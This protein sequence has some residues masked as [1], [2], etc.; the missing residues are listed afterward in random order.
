MISKWKMNTSNDGKFSE[1]KIFFEKHQSELIRSTFD[2]KEIL[3]DHVTVVVHKASQH[4]D[5]VLI[6]DTSLEVEGADVGIQVK[7]MLEDLPKF[8]GRKAIW[9]VY[10]AY[11]ENEQVFIF[12]GEIQGTIVDPRGEKGFGF[13]K[14]FQPLG[15]SHTLAESKPDSVNARAQAV[16]ALFSNHF[17]SIMPILK[18]WNGEWQ[19]T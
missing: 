4:E 2:M 8:K 12:K 13:D 1:F 19:K 18:D 7:S 6:E 16:D 10:L 11:K 15:S 5:R 3:A 17:F 14:V 9:T